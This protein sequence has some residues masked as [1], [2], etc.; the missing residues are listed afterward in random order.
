MEAPGFLTLLYIMFTLPEEQG[1]AELP[2]GNW[3]MAGLFVRIPHSH[4]EHQ[5][6]LIRNIVD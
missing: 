5:H 4:E 2:W 3:I 6:S 1:I